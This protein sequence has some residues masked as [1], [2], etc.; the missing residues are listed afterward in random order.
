MAGRIAIVGNGPVEGRPGAHIDSADIVVRFNEPADTPETT[1]VKTDILFLMNSGKTMQ[2]RLSTPDFRRSRF[3]AGAARIILPYHP[4]I[5]ARYHPK[6]NFL[7]RLKGRRADWTGETLAMCG[8]AGKEILILSPKFYE[9]SCAEL[10]IARTARDSVFPSSGFLAIRYM[11]QEF[12]GKPGEIEL[13]GFSW[14]GWKRH[15]WDK[16]RDWAQAN[17]QQD[18]DRVY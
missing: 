10:G 9:E 13:Y 3:F 12:A 17:L 8:E 6:P 16:E 18:G 11:L 4:S 2:A 5:I 14:K 1:G 15:D 7:S